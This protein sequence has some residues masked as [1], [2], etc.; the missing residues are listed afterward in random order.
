MKPFRIAALLVAVAVAWAGWQVVREP[1]Y[2]G[3]TLSTVLAACDNATGHYTSDPADA[4]RER[5]ALKA[6]D[7]LGP[8]AI[9][10]LLRMVRTRDSKWKTSVMKFLAQK[11]FVETTLEANS[12]NHAGAWGFQVLGT[13]AAKAVPGLV[14]IIRSNISD[15]SR[16]AAFASLESIG[17]AAKDATPYLLR[18]TTNSDKEFRLR[19]KRALVEI[20]PDA[21]PADGWPEEPPPY[22]FKYKNNDR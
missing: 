7:Q 10:P 11:G 9:P 12:W 16:D 20:D 15:D 3:K 5:E 1:R 4:V 13:N 17:P 8:R 22:F 6:L 2:N 21:A 14:R 19:A 18:W